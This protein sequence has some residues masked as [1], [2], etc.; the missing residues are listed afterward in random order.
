MKPL[1]FYIVDVFAEEPYAGNQLAVFHAAGADL[2]DEQMLALARETHFSETTFILSE[3]ER[4]GGYDVRIFMPGEEVPFAGHPTLGTA[5]IIREE[6]LGGKAGQVILNLGVGQIPV[7][8]NA[9]DGVAWMRQI[10]PTL[11]KTHAIAD[12]APVL[13]LEAADFDPLFPIQEVSTGLPSFIIP[14]RSLDAL[15]RT[16]VSAEAYF[17]LMET[18]AAKNLLVFSRETHQPGNDLSVRML[19]GDYLGITEDPATGSA[20]GCLAAYLVEHQALGGAEID[21]RVEQGYEIH[22]PSLLFLRAAKKDGRIQVQ[23]GGRSITVARGE[24][25]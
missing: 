4:N 17:A 13:G 18:T 8:Y 11:G 3:H 21:I 12:L 15:R 2:T 6:L 24:F 5:H 9:A 25:I 22:R 16:R 20:N 7:T 1:P 14:L 19:F 10:E 23:V